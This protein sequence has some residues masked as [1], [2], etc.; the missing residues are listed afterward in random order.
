MPQNTNRDY[1]SGELE[2]LISAFITARAAWLATATPD[3]DLLSSGTL[4]EMFE[5][6]SLALIRYP[7]SAIA[8]V[9]Q[10]VM[11]LLATPELYVMVKEDED[12]TDDLLRTFLSSLITH[13]PALKTN[14]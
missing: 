3:D 2:I 12:Q 8:D 5:A 1:R 14:K 4:F 13:I 11:F 7:C 10:K 9:R 6:S